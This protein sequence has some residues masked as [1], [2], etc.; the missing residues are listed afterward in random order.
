MF[1]VRSLFSFVPR[2]RRYRFWR[3][4]ASLIAAAT[5]WA[6]VALNGVYDWTIAVPVHVDLPRDVALVDTIP[7]R[8][9]LT[10]RT[11]GWSLI[12]LMVARPAQSVIRPRTRATGIHT[13]LLDR[14]DLLRSIQTTVNTGQLVSIAPD[15]MV[16]RV[17]PVERQR[18]PLRASA[19][20]ETKPGFR[21]I[22]P[23]TVEPD[24]I[25]VTTSTRAFPKLTEWRTEPIVLRDVFQPVSRVVRVS[26]SMQGV[27]RTAVRLARIRA[28]VQEIAERTFPDVVVQNR[29]TFR[30]TTLQLVLQPP[31]V[32][33][34]V[35]GGARDLSRLS[36]TDIR[37]FVD[38]IEGADTFGIAQPRVTVPHGSH[39]QI[40]AVLPKQVRYLWRRE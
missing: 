25:V 14:N 34:M 5:L 33:V 38:V 29:T 27:V 15:T 11:D 23:V 39:Y 1:L 32:T 31:R 2:P 3:A 7:Q 20:I 28:D 10:V 21:V 18:V 17:S 12:S 37:A 19:T 16:L 36:P 40:V 6:I 35:R 26:D 13:Y 8:L 30:D 22:G 24:S 9:D 4:L